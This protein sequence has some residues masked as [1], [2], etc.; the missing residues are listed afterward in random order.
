MVAPAYHHGWKRNAV[1]PRL[2]RAAALTQCDRL[3]PSLPH[4]ESSQQDIRRI[5]EHHPTPQRRLTSRCADRSLISHRP[6]S[7][8]PPNHQSILGRGRETGPLGDRRIPTPRILRDRCAS[9]FRH[10]LLEKTSHCHAD[11]ALS[12][13]HRPSDDAPRVQARCETAA[14]SF[15]NFASFRHQAAWR[16]QAF[17]IR[18]GTEKD[19][20]GYPSR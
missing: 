9:L 16:R 3:T 15:P 12:R 5:H 1:P 18:H 11:R 7:S 4:P 20:R 14:A 8:P 19:V 6:E 13:P 2:P 17:R 10:R